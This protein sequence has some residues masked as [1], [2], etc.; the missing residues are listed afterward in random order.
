[1]FGEGRESSSSMCCVGGDGY[2]LRGS[3]DVSDVSVWSFV[4]FVFLRL[5]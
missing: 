2:F 3:V 4:C 5:P 1:M